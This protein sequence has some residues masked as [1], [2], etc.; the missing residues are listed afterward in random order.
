M[1]IVENTGVPVGPVARRLP[2]APPTPDFFTQTLPAALRQENSL[3]AAIANQVPSQ[4][5]NRRGALSSD[6]DPNFDPFADIKGY[7]DRRAAF[8]LANTPEEVAAIKAQI[9]MERRDR[10][11]VAAS[12]TLGEVARLG[13][14]LGDPVSFVPIG[15][16][17]LRAAKGGKS[18]LSVGIETATAGFASSVV[19]EGVLQ[20]Q[21]LTRTQDESAEAIATGTFLSAVL[22]PL[23]RKAL[24]SGRGGIGNLP[25]RVKNDTKIRP[26]T[27]S[28]PTESGGSVELTEAALGKDTKPLLTDQKRGRAARDTGART[29]KGRQLPRGTR[30]ASADR[31]GG[32]RGLVGR[33]AKGETKGNVKDEVDLGPVSPELSARIAEAYRAAGRDP[34]SLEGFSFRVDA[35]GVRHAKNRH[36]DP[37][38]EAARGQIAVTDEDF[39]LIPQIIDNPDDVKFG[40][41]TRKGLDAVIFEKTI[42]DKLFFAVQVRT[43]RRSLSL[44]TMFKRPSRPIAE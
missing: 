14:G 6:I 21:R 38:K 41:V 17:T 7:E 35:G 42:G 12:G 2:D 34:I 36:G 28:D 33:L 16:V 1:P 37:A 24:K 10:A 25:Q 3:G 20:S 23:A 11:T 29:G 43:G 13:A 27:N 19:T 44:A 9:D 31:V 39:E 8:A 5:R 22:G 26:D 32:I 18:L 4:V 40:G 30:D 15:G